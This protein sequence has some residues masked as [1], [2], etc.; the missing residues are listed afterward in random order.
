MYMQQS[1]H[2]PTSVA[3]HDVTN[4]ITIQ[5][6]RAGSLSRKV[7]IQ[8]QRPD[9][10]SHN[11]Q[12]PVRVLSLYVQDSTFADQICWLAQNILWQF[13]LGTCNRVLSFNIVFEQLV[14]NRK[15]RIWEQ[16]RLTSL[17]V[18]KRQIRI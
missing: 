11:L 15:S 5:W 1:Q 12:V 3:V 13:V 6:L 18:T 2:T 4:K 10:H 8:N 16:D 14:K 17:V 9:E 7:T